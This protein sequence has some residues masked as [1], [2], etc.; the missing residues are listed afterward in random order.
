MFQKH[1]K[2]PSNPKQRR[3]PFGS[4]EGQ[5]R[6]RIITELKS[7]ILKKK[8]IYDVLKKIVSNN[9][10]EITNNGKRVMNFSVFQ[11]WVTPSDVMESA[12]KKIPVISCSLYH[13]CT[14]SEKMS[15]TKKLPRRR[16]ERY[17]R[18]CLISCRN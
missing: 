7:P 16:K 5:G 6:F 9:S 8:Y 18:H 2:D 3:I 11:L 1:F 10:F 17:K 15:F 12:I 14:V 13:I 4:A